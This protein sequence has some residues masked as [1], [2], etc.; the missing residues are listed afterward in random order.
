MTPPR[1][2]LITGGSVGI[3]AAIAEEAAKLGWRVAIG[4]RRSDRL[5]SAADVL[6][7]MQAEVFAETLDVSKAG[8]VAAFFDKA[9]AA[10]GTI[11]VVVNNAGHSKPFLFHEYPEEQLSAEVETN[12]LGAMLVTRRA[13]RTLLAHRLRGDVVFVSSDSVRNPRPG[14]TVYGATK[15]A[16]ENLAEGLSQELEG[17]GI[18]VTTLRLGPTISEF[19]ASWSV[20]DICKM[21]DYWRQFGLRDARL[22]GV[23][24]PADAV[25]RALIHAVCQ[26]PGVLLGTVEIQP[27]APMTGRNE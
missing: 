9:E 15:A 16:L 22:L 6:R 11:D 10:L 4:A 5:S 12:L 20:D 26:P 19:A 8:S 17:T 14:H 13:L 7:Q 1:T 2:I 25:A 27:E 18:R 23:L 3:G 24:L 21:P